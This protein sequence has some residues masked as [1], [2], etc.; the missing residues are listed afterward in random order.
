[1]S[2][3]AWTGS[4]LPL[5]CLNVDDLVCNSGPFILV[6]RRRSTSKEWTG[7]DDVVL[8]TRQKRKQG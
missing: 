1:M 8:V 7:Q 6:S 5:G 3:G 2:V 4:N